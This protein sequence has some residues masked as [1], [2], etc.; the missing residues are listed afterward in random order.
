MWLIRFSALSVFCVSVL[1]R[2]RLLI[3]FRVGNLIKCLQNVVYRLI[4]SLSP[5]IESHSWPCRENSS[6]GWRDHCVVCKCVGWWET[7]KLPYLWITFNHWTRGVID[8]FAG[9]RLSPK[10]FWQPRSLFCVSASL[11]ENWKTDERHSA[12]IHTTN[13]RWWTSVDS[14]VVSAIN[15]CFPLRVDVHPK[16]K[17]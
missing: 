14:D 15:T 9:A 13:M 2:F 4:M 10:Q 1:R 6:V 12:L 3:A 17:N 7:I 16:K 8:F 5:T 11:G